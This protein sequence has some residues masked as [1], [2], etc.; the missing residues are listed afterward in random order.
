MAREA[1]ARIATLSPEDRARVHGLARDRLGA[2]VWGGLGWDEDGRPRR[3]GSPLGTIARCVSSRGRKSGSSC[4]P[5]RSWPVDDAAGLRL[6]HPEAVALIC[7]AM[8]EAART[9]AGYD[10]VEAA[11]GGRRSTRQTSSTGSVSCSTSSGS[12]C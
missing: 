12:R 9:G 1:R 4:S 10:A 5:P 7:D 8:L 6:N 11:W 3:R 2:R